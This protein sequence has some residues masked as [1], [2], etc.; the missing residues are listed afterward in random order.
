MC[1]VFAL[2][3]LW[4][5]VVGAAQMRPIPTNPELDSVYLDLHTAS[6]WHHHD[7]AGDIHEDFS[8]KSIAHMTLDGVHLSAIF[9]TL[10]Q[11]V[12]LGKYTALVHQKNDSLH[13]SLLVYPMFRPP[14]HLI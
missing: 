13:E 3:L 6:V 4:H 8:A 9:T 10:G 11:V 1:I 12:T 7:A 5:T 2:M 14:R